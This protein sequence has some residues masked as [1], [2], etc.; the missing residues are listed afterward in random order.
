LR[1]RLVVVLGL[2]TAIVC[3]NLLFPAQ[4]LQAAAT[5]LVKITK[6]ASD[7]T[8]VLSQTTITYQTMKDT[9]PV[10]GDG[11]THY[12]LQGPVFNDNQDERWNQAEDTNVQD[13]DMGA[14]KGTNLKDLCNLVGG[15]AAG[16]TL[17]VKSVD[18]WNKIFAYKNVYQYSS[19]EGPMALTWYQD[20]AYPDTGYSLGMRLLW[21]SD[22]SVNP[23]GL[24][25]L[26]NWDWHQAADSQYWYFY[27]DG[28]QKYPTTTGLSG[29]NISDLIIYST[30]P[31]PVLPVAAF[32]SDV[33]S[34]KAPLSVHF[35]D[36]STG[37][38]TSWSWDF[39]NDG[40]ADSTSQNP[41]YTYTS[42]GTYTV[43]LTVT[44]TAGSTDKIK[45][46]YISASPFWDLNNDHACNLGDVI[47]IGSKWAQSG[48]PGWTAEDINKDG[49]INICDAVT[50]GLHW[51]ETW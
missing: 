43:K 42:I 1:R 10:L 39:N 15:M 45:T 18:G 13:K 26:G 38:P 2:I 16:D 7:R 22:A 29:Y 49:V 50:L 46:N 20:G 34:G 28:D 3:I 48:T 44:N 21:F 25:V 12:Y 41:A 47:I 33:M 19:R 4:I 6:Y 27:Q 40:T 37:S 8:T 14:V 36:Q 24:H 32:T 51:N 17:K 5:K 11:T 23:W 31:A 30:Q 9:L 35:T